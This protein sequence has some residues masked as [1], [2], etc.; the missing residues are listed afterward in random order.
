MHAVG[1]DE[2]LCAFRSVPSKCVANSHCL[3]NPAGFPLQQAKPVADYSIRTGNCQVHLDE[4]LSKGSHVRF[5]HKMLSACAR[6]VYLKRMEQY[7]TPCVIRRTSSS[8]KKKKISIGI[9]VKV[10]IDISLK[11]MK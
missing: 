5:E 4:P 1:L 7:S 2:M 9:E 6:S 8:K 11:Q 10:M 3:M